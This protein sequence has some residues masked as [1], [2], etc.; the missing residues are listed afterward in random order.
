MCY[1]ASSKGAQRVRLQAS[2]LWQH[3][4]AIVHNPGVSALF[5]L[6]HKR[7]ATVDPQTTMLCMN[8]PTQPAQ[9]HSTPERGFF[10][11]PAAP[12]THRSK[13]QRPQWQHGDQKGAG[14]RGCKVAARARTKNGCTHG[15]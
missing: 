9:R 4:A 15:R 8:L 11:C 3:M 1:T 6:S 10:G 7:Q 12:G 5:T 14:R 2:I 13:Q